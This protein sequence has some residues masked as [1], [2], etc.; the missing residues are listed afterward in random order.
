MDMALDSDPQE[1]ALSDM[2]ALNAARIGTRPEKA[3]EHVIR[4]FMLLSVLQSFRP[5]IYD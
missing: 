2:R 1:S 4:P 5:A 3:G